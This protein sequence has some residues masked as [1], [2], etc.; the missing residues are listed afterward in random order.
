MTKA[1]LQQYRAVCAEI[2]QL[3]RDINEAYRGGMVTDSVQGSPPDAPYVLGGV[4]I[5]GLSEDA[6]DRLCG[7]GAKLSRK[8]D[9][10]IRLRD[11]IE[12]YFD[13]LD[14]ETAVIL[15][16]KYVEGR[17]WRDIAQELGKTEAGV[18]MRVKR[19]FVNNP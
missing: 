3:R 5:R 16:G 4:V 10:R 6:Y 17:T 1:E 8:M 12:D 14:H 18:K 13:S 9:E 2:E 7:M 11:E 15:R 19:I